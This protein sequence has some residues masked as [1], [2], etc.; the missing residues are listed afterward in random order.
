MINAFMCRAITTVVGLLWPAY[1]CYK[2]CS[3]KEASAVVLRRW[4]TTWVALATFIACERFLDNFLFWLPLYNEAKVAFVV[5]LARLHGAEYVYEVLLQ[6]TLAE[7]EPWIDNSARWVRDWLQGH[8]Q[9][10]L[11]TAAAW[12]QAQMFQLLR[13]AA[14]LQHRQ[15]EEE[16]AAAEP[17]AAAVPAAAPPARRKA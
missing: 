4:C 8:V 7:Y 11:Q 3:K 12:V 1:Q 17:P 16:A 9:Y 10:N 6:P 15:I 13:V 5:F 14:S 2:T